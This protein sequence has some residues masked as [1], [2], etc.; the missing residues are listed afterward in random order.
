MDRT[1]L[2]RESGQVSLLYVATIS[3]SI[4]HFLS[5]YAAHFRARGWRVDAAA[6]GCSTDAGLRAAFDNAYEL[7]LSRSI[8]DVGAFVRSVRSVAAV[9]EVGYDIVHVHTPIAGFVTRMAARRLPPDRR[10]AVAYTAHGFHFYPGGSRA[11]NALFLAAE[12]IGGRWTDRLVVINNEDHEAAL[13]HRIVPAGR[14]VRMPGIG[15]DTG[16][17]AR[18]NVAIEAV[19]RIR[20]QMDAGP[21]TPVF[22]YMGELNPNKR[23]SDVIAALAVMRHSEAR[24]LLMGTGRDQARLE[25]DVRQRGLEHRVA[26]TGFVADVR[27]ALGAAAALI[28]ASRREGLAR[29]IMEALAL[30]VPVI[31]SAARGNRELVDEGSGLIFPVGDVGALANAMDWFVEHPN[32]ALA[33][34]RRG[35]ARM[36]ERF[37]QQIVIRM[38]E[39]MYRAMLAQRPNAVTSHT[40]GPRR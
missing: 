15:V 20:D 34:G 14:L 28:L 4:R 38:H 32:E 39:E 18:S 21:E 25:A 3:D 17:Y 5:P 11:T 27:P 1:V 29:S 36:V 31:A 40:Q 9:L 23:Q 24:L 33:M 35:H 8:V 37:D 26:F 6:S 7:P 10:P 22:V 30:E 16:V 13:R 12:R 2:T 19:A